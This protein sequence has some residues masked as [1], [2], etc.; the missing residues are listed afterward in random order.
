MCMHTYIFKKLN[1]NKLT[2]NE[3]MGGDR[4][5]IPYF[6]II[7]IIIICFVQ[8]DANERRRGARRRD[9][10]QDARRSR[11]PCCVVKLLRLLC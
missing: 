2:N 1:D 7:I 3:R 10:T 6:L 11:L 8:G 5:N 9:D 4:G